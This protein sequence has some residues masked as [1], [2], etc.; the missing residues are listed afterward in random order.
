M[1]AYEV[2][3]ESKQ[4]TRIPQRTVYEKLRWLKEQDYVVEIQGKLFK[5]MYKR[6]IRKIY[7]DVSLKGM[8]AALGDEKLSL[9]GAFFERLRS[10]L[11]IPPKYEKAV[12]PIVSI[13]AYR[14]S[15]VPRSERRKIETE[16]IFMS[17][18]ETIAASKDI[19]VYSIIRKELKLPPINELMKRLHITD[20][21]SRALDSFLSMLFLFK[22][23]QTFEFHK[24]TL[25]YHQYLG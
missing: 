3:K 22:F 23:P 5:R 7:Y 20:E 2:W 4:R 24:R 12:K 19:G 9:K 13:W 16:F 14:E 15:G 21:D 11:H 8:L 17:V 1:T 18:M 10:T 6:N 25:P